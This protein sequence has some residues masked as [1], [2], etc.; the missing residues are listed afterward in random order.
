MMVMMT[1]SAG[2]GDGAN[3]GGGTATGTLL[4]NGSFGVGTG[5]NQLWW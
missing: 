4:V 3:N 2:K 5:T 1:G